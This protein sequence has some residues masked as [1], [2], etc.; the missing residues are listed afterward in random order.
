MT[1]RPGLVSRMNPPP[2]GHARSPTEPAALRSSDTIFSRYAPKERGLAAV[3]PRRLGYVSSRPGQ[4]RR[5][6]SDSLADLS[7]PPAC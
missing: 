4:D 2:S 5:S 1:A 6:S 7:R 3:E